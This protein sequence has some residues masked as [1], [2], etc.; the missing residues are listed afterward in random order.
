MGIEQPNDWPAEFGPGD[1]LPTGMKQMY[2][3]GRQL[4]KTYKEF[5]GEDFTYKNV[6][7]VASAYNRTLSSADCQV[8]GL[9]GLGNGPEIE[10]D[11]PK[12]YNPPIPNFD[13]PF[14]FGKSALPHRLTIAPIASTSKRYNLVF[15]PDS[16]LTCPE[17][18]KAQ[19]DFVQDLSR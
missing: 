6:D 14:E 13:I 10:N 9:F 19:Q 12:Y 16:A 15:T 17:L 7:I 18:Y 4:A 11:D 3:L 8:I 2:L 5:F 1:L